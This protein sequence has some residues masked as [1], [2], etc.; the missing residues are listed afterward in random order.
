VILRADRHTDNSRI[1]FTNRSSRRKVAAT[2]WERKCM[3]GLRQANRQSSSGN[4]R[5]S[6]RSIQASR[7]S[8]LHA[9]NRSLF[10]ATGRR[11][12]GT[13]ISRAR[14]IVRRANTRRRGSEQGHFLLELRT[15]ADA[16][17]VGYPNAGKSTLR[18]DLRG[19]TKSGRL[20]IHDAASDHRRG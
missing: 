3:A 14:A 4:D 1:F 6:R 12:Q 8:I 15:I 16:G 11:R 13:F 7:L 17:L 2:E 19:S 18:E 9:M 20:S 5:L 10:C